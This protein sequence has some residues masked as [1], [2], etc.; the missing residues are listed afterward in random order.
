MFNDDVALGLARPP[1]RWSYFYKNGDGRRA[2]LHP[3]GPGHAGDH[4][5]HAALPAR[6]TTSSSR[7]AR[8]TASIIRRRAAAL[9][10]GRSRAARIEPPQRYR[11]EYGQ[12][13]EH[14]P[15]CERDLRGPTRRWLTLDERGTSSA[16]QGRRP[17][18]APTPRPPPASTWSAG[19]ASL[20]VHV[21]RRRLRAD[22]RHG[23]TSRRRCTR[24]S[25]RPASW[26]ARS[27]RACSTPPARRSRCRTPTPTSTATRCSTTCA[28]I[29]QPARRR[30]GSFTLHPHG[31]PH[32]PHP[33]TIVAS[34][35][36]DAHR[37]AGR[38][39]RHLPAAEADPPGARVRR[40]E[41]SVSWL[42]PPTSAG[43][44]SA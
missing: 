38:H 5:R 22:H 10:R 29:R 37:R 43:T 9:A 24:R 35:G 13:L 25:R 32:G 12:L 44:P 6:A 40:P 8:S 33:G 34:L 30:G 17:A 15:Y 28:A 39:G 16:H 4:V 19:T 18:D 14:S 23:S 3:R 31:I 27:R 36:K 2:A 7:A 1:S 41:L 20:P 42:D 26:S 21:Q 11:N